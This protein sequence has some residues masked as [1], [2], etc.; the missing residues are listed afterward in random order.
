[1]LKPYRCLS[2]KCLAVAAKTKN[3]NP[4]V[5]FLLENLG[6]KGCNS[7]RDL[8]ELEVIHLLI[9]ADGGPIPSHSKRVDK[10]GNQIYSWAVKCKPEADHMPH[11]TT[12]KE[13]ATCPDC[14]S[15]TKD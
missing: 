13:A 6:C 5:Q 2:A 12:E 9:P 8:V 10:D 1:M 7:T 3:H 4:P 15:E 11:M 14:L